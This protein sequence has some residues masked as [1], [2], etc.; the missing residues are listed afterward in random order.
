MLDVEVAKSKIDKY[1]R[2]KE[3]ER[4]SVYRCIAGVPTIGVG[5]T[6]YPDG[7]KVTMRDQPITKERMDEMLGI[8]IGRYVDTV[9]EIVDHECTTMQL[10][11][12]VMLAYNIGLNAL[13]TSTLIKLHKKGQYSAAANAFRMWDQFTNPATGKKEQSPALLARRIQEAAIYLSDNLGTRPSPQAVASE[14][15]ILRSP[16]AQAGAAVVSVGAGVIGNAPDL[17]EVP[18]LPEVMTQTT[19]VLQQASTVAATMNV[20]L[21]VVG[22]LGLVAF[23]GVALYYRWKQRQSGFA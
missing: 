12:L 11:A 7:R 19:T 22:G 18:A 10:V 14:T 3:G 8:E 16:I 20:N 9:L 6:S 21:W 5:A 15:K 1:L 2:R 17:A 23:G 4:L 13:R